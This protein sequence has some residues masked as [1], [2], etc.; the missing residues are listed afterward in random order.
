MWEPQLEA[1]SRFRVL[2]FDHPG[3]GDSPL[4]ATAT[5]EAFAA[6]L[7]ALLDAHGVERASLCGLS[8]GGA[9]AMQVATGSPERVDRLVLASTAARFPNAEVYGDRARIVRERGLEPV[10]DTVVDRWFTAPFRDSEPGTVRRYRDMLV[11]TPPEGYARCCE[12]VRDF[13]A[14]PAL[15]DVRAATLVIAGADDPA[16]TPQDCERLARSISGARLIVL[17]G[18]A[19]LANVEQPDAFSQALVSH[20]AA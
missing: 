6:E 16:T 10:A 8:L 11:S 20:L 12:A 3:H 17:G 18:S 14:R 1:L 7:L 5:V 9:V 19:H 2:R 15:G 4:A 13:D